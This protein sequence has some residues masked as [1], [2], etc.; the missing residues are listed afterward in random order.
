MKD[1]LAALKLDAIVGLDWETY[2]ADDYSLRKMSTT[3]YIVDARFKTHMV[4]VQWH[5]ER[6]ARV[7]NPTEFKAFCRETDWKRT[8]MLAHH[9]HFDGL[10]ASHHFKAKPAFYLDTLSMA[11]PLMP[12]TVGGS[13][14]A[15]CKAFGLRGKVGAQSLENVKGVRDMSIKQ[16]HAL[17]KYAGNDIE[18]TWLLF[19]KLLPYTPLD[20]LRLIDLTVKMY[21]Q[22]TLLVDGEMAQQVSDD[23][24]TKKAKLLKKAVAEKSAVMSN[25]QF[26]M[27]LEALGVDVPLKISKTTGEVTYAFSKQD[28]AF[29]ELL[30]HPNKGVRTLVEALLANKSTILETR[31][32]K[33]ATR[34]AIGAQPVYLNYCGA[35][36]GRWSGGDKMNWQ[37][38]NRGSDLRKSIHAPKGHTLIIADLAQIEARMLAW[39]AGQQD[40]LEAFRAGKDVYAL[41]AS[42]IYG[43]EISKDKNP[44]ERFVG[45]VAT[46][47][48]GYGAG[49][50]RFAEMLRIGAL[51]PPVDITDSVARDIVSAWRSSNSHIVGFWRRVESTS[52]SAFFGRQTLKLGVLTFSGAENHGFIQLPGGFVLRYDGIEADGDGMTYISR[53]RRGKDGPSVTRTCLHGGFTTENI[54]QALSRRVLAEQMLA[55]TDRLP[56]VRIAST[57]HDELL[58]VVPKARAATNLKVVKQIMSTPPE[59]APDLPLAVD[60]HISER[61]DK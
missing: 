12:I 38:F 50:V 51:G 1:L 7:L 32:A 48:L 5:H 49:G 23:E 39:I 61:Y 28:I 29:K 20:E 34:A 54:V 9:T 52:R 14:D 41:A 44:D 35:H 43:K 24:A 55:I 42:K 53:Y 27:M 26:A 22:P 25:P 18:Q 21:A 17:A 37:N 45:K 11:R 36:T 15:L 46:L 16:F 40:I 8:G 59:W 19:K 3:E 60:A 13:L 47:A 6:K 33:M 2:Y 31:A 57:T 58:P 30:K 56:K 10:I 4:S